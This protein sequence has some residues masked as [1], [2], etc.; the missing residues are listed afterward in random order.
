MLDAGTLEVRFEQLGVIALPPGEL[1]SE[2]NDNSMA[3]LLIYGTAYVILDCD[4]EVGEE[5]QASSSYT[6]P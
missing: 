2:T 1:F 3:V 4:A 6:R 5:L